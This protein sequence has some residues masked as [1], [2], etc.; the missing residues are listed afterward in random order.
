M[1]MLTV[2]LTHD[3]YCQAGPPAVMG[4]FPFLFSPPLYN[5]LFHKFGT[6]LT[7]PVHPSSRFMILLSILL[8]KQKQIEKIPTGLT[9]TSTSYL[10]S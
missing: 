2:V 4:H 3:H 9:I 10:H 7:P 6:P 8:R 5:L 1:I